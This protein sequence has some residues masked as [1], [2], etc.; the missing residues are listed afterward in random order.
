MR[1]LF[2]HFFY[3]SSLISFIIFF[4]SSIIAEPCDLTLIPLNQDY[5]FKPGNRQ[6]FVNILEDLLSGFDVIGPWGND[7]SA[8]FKFRFDRF[9]DGSIVLQTKTNSSTNDKTE[10]HGHFKRVYNGYSLH[11]AV[12]LGVTRRLTA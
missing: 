10:L 3:A 12:E 4:S 6:T 9:E 2:F 1:K 8:I 5:F 11:S 7:P